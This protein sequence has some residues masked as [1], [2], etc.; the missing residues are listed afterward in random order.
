MILTVAN[1]M[2]TFTTAIGKTMFQDF[3]TA[4]HGRIEAA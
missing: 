1:I 4:I 2:A 3:R